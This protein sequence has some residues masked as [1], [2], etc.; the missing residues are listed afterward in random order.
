MARSQFFMEIF[1]EMRS[2][3]GGLHQDAFGKVSIVFAHLLRALRKL[4]GQFLVT[5]VLFAVSFAN[6]GNP[7]MAI[8]TAGVYSQATRVGFVATN[9]A[10]NA[11]KLLLLP[12]SLM[13]T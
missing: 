2:D 3:L 9:R 5:S 1:E 12:V 8:G 7:L 13:L 6:T 4:A 10:G 11:L